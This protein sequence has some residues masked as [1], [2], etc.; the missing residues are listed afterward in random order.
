VRRSLLLFALLASIS[1][2]PLAN[3]P[4]AAAEN[5]AQ[6]PKPE[7]LDPNHDAP[8]GTFYKSFHSNVIGG[9]V[10]YL[11]A[12]PKGYEGGAK[13][14]PV[15]YWLHPMNGNQRVGATVFLPFY[16]TAV[17]SGT[18]PPAIVI[19][20]NGMSRGMYLNLQN[21]VEN[22]IIQDLIPHVDQTYRTVARREGRVIQGFS[23]GGFGAGHLGFKYPGLFGTIV[24]NSGALRDHGWFSFDEHPIKLAEKNAD[25]LRQNTRI[26]M[27]CGTKD[28]L[29]P[30][31]QELHELLLKLGIEHEWVTVPEVPHNAFL[32]YKTLGSK[33]FDIHRK[34]FQAL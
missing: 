7:W 2:A 20:V 18:L 5:P 21:P 33:A 19:L 25:Q 34:A 27:G 23:M 17:E 16:N 6:A 30:S 31:N 15:I 3:P 24:I 12:L 14:Y 29:L 26:F 32:F 28:D 9:D 13:R 10:S 11:V 22:V 4:A 8:N 1:V